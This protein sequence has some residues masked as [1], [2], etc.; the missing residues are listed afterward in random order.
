[1]GRMASAVLII[2]TSDGHIAQKQT[3]R[4]KIMKKLAMTAVAVIA[5]ATTG[6]IVLADCPGELSDCVASTNGQCADQDK[7][8]HSPDNCTCQTKFAYNQCQCLTPP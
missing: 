4:N 7:A 5:T 3:K 1:M 6:Y 8:C 2:G